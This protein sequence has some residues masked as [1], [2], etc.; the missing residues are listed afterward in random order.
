[1]D[2]IDGMDGMDR[3]WLSGHDEKLQAILERYLVKD[4]IPLIE[5]YD[6][7]YVELKFMTEA[8]PAARIEKDLYYQS[9]PTIRAL[10]R[11]VTFG[12]SDMSDPSALHQYPL[13]SGGIT[14]LRLWIS[15][16]ESSTSTIWVL[17]TLK[18][19]IFTLL[20]ITLEIQDFLRTKGRKTLLDG[21]AKG[22]IIR[23]QQVHLKEYNNSV[24]TLS[25]D[26]W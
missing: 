18:R 17:S 26:I 12:Y 2:G 25:I 4:L 20:D 6:Y 23:V 5:S 7:E 24:L 13:T 16:R 10:S 15:A 3:V 14:T 8:L 21:F 1:M 11:N 19:E 22:R 9:W